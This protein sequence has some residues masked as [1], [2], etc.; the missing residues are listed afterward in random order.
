MNFVIFIPDEMRAESVGCYG[1]PLSPTPNIDNLAAQGVRFDQ[2]HVQH[3]VCTPSRCSLMTG[4]YPHVRGHRTLWH[5]L[6]PDEPNLLKYLK[7]AGYEVRWY[8]KNDLLAGD[9]FAG[10]VTSAVRRGGKTGA[11]NPYPLDDPRHYSFL[12]EPGESTREEHGDWRDVQAA[13]EFVSSRPSGPFAI[14]LPIVFPHCPYWAPGEWHGAVDPRDLAPPRPPDLPGKPDFHDLIRKSRRLD[15]VDEDHFRKIQA[16]YLGMIGFVDE[17]LGR[18]LDALDEANL[19]DETAVFVLSDHGDWAGDY[20][21]VEKWPSALDD[22]LTRIPLVARVPG[23]AKGHV[24]GEPVEAFDVMATVLELAEVPAGHT[25][26]ARSL[27]SQLRGAAGDPNRAAFAEGGYSLHEPHCFEGVPERDAGRIAPGHIYYPKHEVQQEHPESV[28][29]SVMVRTMTHKLIYRAQ[30]VCE[31]YD[32]AAD[33]RELSNVYDRA[34][35]AGVR[36][37]L[38]SRLLNWYVETCD[39]TPFDEDSRGLPAG[40]MV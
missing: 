38:E 2:C 18:L 11:H 31:L 1:H 36:R 35:C 12:Y 32:L 23:G 14:Y 22:C 15:E 28:S 34:E 20:G 8:G 5:A 30:G 19:A 4:W 27:V 40:L 10:S 21:L 9:S 16:V 6:R 3:T 33:P 13:I 39:V 25:H 37:E 26:F 7:Q 29:R 17:M 24:V